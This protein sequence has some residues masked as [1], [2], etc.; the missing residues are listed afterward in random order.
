MSTFGLLIAALF[1]PLFPFSAVFNQI[2]QRLPNAWLRGLLLL[3]WPQAGLAI[4]AQAGSRVPDWLLTW[5]IASALFYAF[6]MLATRELG[7]WTGFMA[8]SLWALLWLTVN[9]DTSALDRSLSA[10]VFSVPLVLLA[11]L[12]RSIES[13]VGAAYAGAPGGLAQIVPR[14][15]AVVVAAI[16]AAT[17]TPLSAGFF[18]MLE[19]IVNITPAAPTLA[20][21]T[22]LTW[23]FWSWASARMLQGLIAGPGEPDGTPD[24]SV[25]AMALMLGVLAALVFASLYWV[26]DLS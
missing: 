5:A 23:F 19:A 16:L 2:F 17:A 13:R 14:L 10:L 20:C 21:I 26:G 6:R 15:A 11:I 18:I 22:L 3:A 12:T 25:A 24:L 8:S 9:G 1:L 7:I 4:I